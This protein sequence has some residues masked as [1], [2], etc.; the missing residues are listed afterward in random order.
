[1]V[2]CKYCVSDCQVDR[3]HA[4]GY[5]WVISMAFS[6]VFTSQFSFWVLLPFSKIAN[7]VSEYFAFLPDVVLNAE[8]CF[9]KMCLQMSP[10]LQK[11]RLERYVNCFMSVTHYSDKLR[12]LWCPIEFFWNAWYCYV[13]FSINAANCFFNFSFF[14]HR[15]GWMGFL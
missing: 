9:F 1:M 5:M 15:T 13:H 6:S 10:R 2:W 12:S 4:S 8:E 7:K 14:G 11:V 3:D